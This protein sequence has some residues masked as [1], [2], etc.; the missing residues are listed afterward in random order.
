M[1][2]EVNL[3][4]KY[5][6]I[7]LGA[8]LILAGAIYGYAQSGVPNPGHDWNEI[9]NVPADL[10]DG[11]DF[12]ADT[13]TNAITKCANNKFLDGDGSCR[14]ASQIVSDGGGGGS[15]SSKGL[16]TGTGKETDEHGNNRRCYVYWGDAT[17]PSYT[18]I[19]P[20]GSSKVLTGTGSRDVGSG[21]TESQNYYVCI[22]N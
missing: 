1:K 6:F 9:G 19:C 18:L 14:T 21:D 10:A 17:C 22:K 13:D 4:K 8:I 2:L 7:L 20:S 12:E 16:L 15:S 11:D 5:F 3:S